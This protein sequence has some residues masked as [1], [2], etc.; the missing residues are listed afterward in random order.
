MKAGNDMRKIERWEIAYHQ[1][2]RSHE[3][4]ENAMDG[5]YAAKLRLCERAGLDPGH[6]PD[7]EEIVERYDCLCHL[8]SKLM[9]QYGYR[10]GAPPPE[11]H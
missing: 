7:L 8:Y 11:D 1:L 5:I 2:K 3:L 4:V 9:Y 10:D 6:D